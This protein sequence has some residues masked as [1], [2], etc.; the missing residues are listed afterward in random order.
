M[1]TSTTNAA[2]NPWPQTGS[3]DTAQYANDY[4]PLVSFPSSMQLP[5]TAAALTEFVANIYEELVTQG[6]E[7]IEAD[8]TSFFQN[9]TTYWDELDTELTGA[10]QALFT[11]ETDA[12]WTDVLTALGF[13]SSEISN[14]ITYLETAH[15]N[16]ANAWANWETAFTN[17]S[18][19]TIADLTSWWNTAS[20][21]ATNAWSNWET[22]LTNTSQATIADLTTWWNDIRSDIDNTWDWLTGSSTAPTVGTTT[23]GQELITGLTDVWD[24][25]TG[26]TTPTS[27]SQVQ[28]AAVAGIGGASSMGAAAQAIMDY[29]AQA[30]TGSATTGNSFGQLANAASGTATTASAAQMVAQTA[31]LVQAQ[32]TAAKAAWAAFGDLTADVTFPVGP[33]YAL[34]SMPTISVTATK[35]A[36]GYIVTPDNVN[37]LSVLFVAETVGTVT[38]VYINVYSV[39]ST[40]LCTNVIAGSNIVGEIGNLE[41][42]IYDDFASALAVTPGEQYAVE[43]V[44]TGSGSLTMMGL[45]SSW[46]PTNSLVPAGTVGGVRSFS[47]AH[48][49]TGVGSHTTTAGTVFTWSHILAASASAI[50]IEFNVFDLNSYTVSSVKVGTTSATLL[51][52]KANG[53]ITGYLYELLSPPTGTQTITV[54]LSASNYLTGNSDSYNGVSSFGTVATNSGSSTAASV[55][56]SSAVGQ[57]A[58]AVI[59]AG[60]TSALTAF[61]QTSRWNAGDNFGGYGVFGDAAGASTVSFSATTPSDPWLAIGVSLVGVSVTA[62]ATFTPVASTSIPLFGLSSNGGTT[63]PVFAP[64]TT[65]YTAHGTYTYTLPTWFNLGVDYLD[66]IA[67]GPGGGGGGT[68]ASPGSAGSNTTVTVGGTTVTAA[69]GAGASTGNTNAA[70]AVGASPGNETYLTVTYY[71]GGTSAYSYGLVAAGSSPGGGGAG[72]GNSGIYGYGGAAGIWATHT[73]NPTGTT[74]SITVG[75]GGAGSPLF[76]AEN[77]ADGAV[78]I[79]ARQA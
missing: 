14:F 43:V 38:D 78:W 29:L 58:V 65:S 18:Q 77:G 44:V 76:G 39:G 51:G 33:T 74:A 62:P 17:T 71:G 12:F 26:T 61:N 42:V 27:A 54:T 2:P 40:G 22:A 16:A 6:I 9:V 47:P 69:A 46:A 8:L 19:A 48:D 66:V 5:D 56:V 24:W 70:G 4:N 63:T 34:S 10:I 55:S 28:V 15:T 49:A 13:T 45:G 73:F 25:L 67:L 75:T 3:F 11:G 52:S 50:L 79:V 21:N 37:K 20:T 68:G 53:T 41:A 60:G 7:E 30:F 36:I 32:Q 57:I 23:I 35:S 59:F 1:A 64:E 72:G 31:T